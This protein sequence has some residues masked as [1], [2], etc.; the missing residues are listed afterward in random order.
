MN[1]ISNSGFISMGN[2]KNITGSAIGEGAALYMGQQHPLPTPESETSRSDIGVVTILAVEAAAVCRSLGLEEEHSNGR[3]YYTRPGHGGAD[4]ASIA[5]TRAAG[6]GHQA[7]MSALADL[8]R[9]Y[10]PAV[11]VIVGIAGAIR[12][13]LDIGDVAVATRAVYYDLRKE[14]PAGTLRRGSEREAPVRVV[15]AVNSFFTERGEPARLTTAHGDA[16][17]FSGPIASGESVVADADSDIRKYLR[18]YNDKILS[19]DMEA[20]ALSQHCHET[21]VGE[22]GRQP[23]WVVIRGIS[24]KANPDKNDDAHELASWNAAETLRE[25]VPYLSRAARD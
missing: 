12:P 21:S 10:S 8:A 16:R 17:I 23:G 15:H 4:S 25:L 14:T 9:T 2:V 7:A 18:Q 13:D 5:M 22:T 3:V 19:V 6:Q 20:A 11:Y 1:Y 24:D